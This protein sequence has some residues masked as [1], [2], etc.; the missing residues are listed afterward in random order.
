MNFIGI[1]PF[2]AL[3]RRHGPV[4]FS[5]N[6]FRRGNEV[7]PFIDGIAPQAIF[8]KKGMLAEAVKLG[9]IGGA[10]G[11]SNISSERRMLTE[12]VFETQGSRNVFIGDVISVDG[13]IR[14]SPSDGSLHEIIAK[15]EF[16]GILSSIL[17]NAIEASPVKSKVEVALS[18][19]DE[20]FSICVTDEG[21]GFGR[22]GV[23]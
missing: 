9:Y 6:T 21:K 11:C 8:Y 4:F 3:F 7:K 15:A 14:L 5:Q 10:P 17:S 16:K 18:K 13:I 23:F 20:A 19:T 1:D 12:L 2:V 22:V